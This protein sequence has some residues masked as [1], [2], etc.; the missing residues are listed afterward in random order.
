VPDP[1]EQV[2]E[3]A[4]TVPV[5]IVLIDGRS[6]SGKTE[7]GTLVAERLNAQLVRLDDLYPG[8]DGL[9][10]GSQLVVTDLLERHRWRRWDWQSSSFAE[11]H[12]LDPLRAL[13][14]DG[15]GSL[16]GSSR[17][18]STLGV[19]VE[20]DTAR[21]KARALARDGEQ[22]APHWDAWAEQ[23]QRFIDREHPRQLADLIVN[24]SRI[25]PTM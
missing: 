15:C 5:P 8:W 13:V 23:E 22:Y 2:V 19:W 4:R 24:G 21:R 6:G 16:R 17:D 12:S 3:R 9:D 7:L 20:L 11:E 1:I 18:L 10:A 14:I 25:L